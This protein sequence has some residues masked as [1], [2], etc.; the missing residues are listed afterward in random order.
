[1]CLYHCLL[2]LVAE[3]HGTLNLIDT[4]CNMNKPVIFPNIIVSLHCVMSNIFE[5]F[6]IFIIKWLKNYENPVLYHLSYHFTF[7]AGT[8]VVDLYTVV[9]QIHR[10]WEIFFHPGK[11]SVL[12]AESNFYKM[13]I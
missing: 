3:F 2:N 12:V 1:M 9:D 7:N 5:I 11:L 13:L 10:G 6:T 8:F 4:A